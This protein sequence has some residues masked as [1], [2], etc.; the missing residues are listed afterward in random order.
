M[1]RGNFCLSFAPQKNSL[2]KKMAI[3]EILEEVR[4]NRA[5]HA[6][7]FHYDLRAIY[8]DLK[9]SEKEHILTGHPFVEPPAQQTPANKPLHRTTAPQQLING[10]GSDR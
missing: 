5:A 1:K 8:E 3:D 9:K 7:K 4:S 10:H 6:A 2:V